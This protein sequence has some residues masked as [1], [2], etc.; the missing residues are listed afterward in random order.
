MEQGK[1]KVFSFIKS[2]TTNSKT[3]VDEQFFEKL[4]SI[5]RMKLKKTMLGCINRPLVLMLTKVAD[6]CCE[7]TCGAIKADL[8]VSQSLIYFSNCF[9]K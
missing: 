2:V 8:Q 1:V 5:F 3:L 9:D 4:S 6:N 7:Y